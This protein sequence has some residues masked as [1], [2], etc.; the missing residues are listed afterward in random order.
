MV[1]GAKLVGLISATDIMKLGYGENPSKGLA[2]IMDHAHPLSEV[3][4]RDLVTIGA[5][6]TIRKA[7]E[8]LSTGSY[9]ALPVVDGEGTLLGMVTSTDLVRF[10]A[11]QW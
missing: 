3:M 5:T 7:A 8:L 6:Q 4:Q 2:P 9:H 1:D 10:L 11:T